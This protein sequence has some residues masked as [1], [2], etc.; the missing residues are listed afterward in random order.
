VSLTLGSDAEFQRPMVSPDG[1]LVAYSSF[2]MTSGRTAEPGLPGVV[3][4]GNLLRIHVLDLVAGTDRVIPPGIDPIDPTTPVDQWDA[5][6]SPD[7]ARIAFTADRSNGTVQLVIAPTNGSEI[8]RPIGPAVAKPGDPNPI[9]DFAPDG[10][11]LIAAYP[12]EDTAR[13]VPLDGGPTS[14]IPWDGADLPNLQRL[15]P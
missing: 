4:E 6:F 12:G 2:E 14:P 8:G 9:F 7:G 11:S 10:Q 1:R 15:A 3:Y 13:I 5:V